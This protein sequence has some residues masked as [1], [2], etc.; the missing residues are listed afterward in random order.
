MKAI[1]TA[2]NFCL[3]V[4]GRKT[5]LPPRARAAASATVTTTARRPPARRRC[6]P[7]SG[8]RD[9][10]TKKPAFSCSDTTGRQDLAQAGLAR[11]RLEG[12]RV[13]ARLPRER[14]QLSDVL[15]HARIGGHQRRRGWPRRSSQLARARRRPRRAGS[16]A[17]PRAGRW[18]AAAMR[19]VGPHADSGH[20]GQGEERPGP[21][22]KA[23]RRSVRG[24][25]AATDDMASV[26]TPDDPASR[27]SLPRG[28]PGAYPETAR[29]RPIALLGTG[30]LPDCCFLRRIPGSFTRPVGSRSDR[31][32]VRWPFSRR[33]R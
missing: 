23:G 20:E 22:G 29:T 14:D 11:G 30:N 10:A 32:V 24:R 21:G 19:H 7:R 18:I 28:V 13:A 3:T 1:G 8:R 5:G 33:F 25:C 4:G 6:G 17:C 9:R 31:V 26:S 16:R 15:A 2:A 27:L 12:R